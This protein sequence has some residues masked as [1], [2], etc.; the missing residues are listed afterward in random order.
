MVQ[1]SD[2][3]HDPFAVPGFV[4]NKGDRRLT[5]LLLQLTDILQ[6]PLFCD[7]QAVLSD[8]QLC[9]LKLSRRELQIGGLIVPFCP[10]RFYLFQFTT[11]GAQ[12]CQPRAEEL[13]RRLGV[14]P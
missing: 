3:S 4:S 8:L 6:K 13:V 14:V 2:L 7:E 12:L 11:C 1:F 10:A 9:T 5:H